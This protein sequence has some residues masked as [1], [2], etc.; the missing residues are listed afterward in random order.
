M[1]EEDAIELQTLPRR[2]N[3]PRQQSESAAGR[4]PDPTGYYYNMA[5][6][7]VATAVSAASAGTTSTQN[8]SSGCSSNSSDD[9]SSL[10]ATPENQGNSVEGVRWNGQN[11]PDR[12]FVDAFVEGLRVTDLSGRAKLFINQRFLGLY[13]SYETKHTQTKR[14]YDIA[15]FTVTV[16]AIAVPFLITIENDIRSDLKE[17]ICSSPLTNF[18]YYATLLLSLMVTVVNGLS[19]LYQLP[20]KYFV[21]ANARQKLQQEGWSFLLLRGAYARYR[22]HRDC[23]Q[24]FLYRTE[25]I[26][27]DS[28]NNHI[29]I[30][31]NGGWRR[32]SGPSSNNHRTTT[33]LDRFSATMMKRADD[34]NSA[35]EALRSDVDGG[36]SSENLVDHWFATGAEA[37]SGI[38]RNRDLLRSLFMSSENR[39][40]IPIVVINN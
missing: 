8:T 17:H 18:L 14:R 38:Q 4:L 19:E 11:E 21:Q 5:N 6:T 33:I 20:K 22:T 7:D 3:Y 10:T 40:E 37:A 2:D 35:N 12:E 13:K 32:S 34:N 24:T 1:T 29:L 25:Y 23:W 15:R 27:H 39:A 31:S 16:G 30:Q 36:G 28:A 9:S 26:H